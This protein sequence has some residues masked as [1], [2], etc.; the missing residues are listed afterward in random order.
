MAAKPS[1]LPD[2]ATGG[3]NTAEPTAGEKI[4][5]W[6]LGGPAV[7]SYFNWL[8]KTTRDWLE[9]LK[10]GVMEGA[11][12]FAG[13]ITA[14]AGLTADAGQHITVSGAGEFKHGDRTIFIGPGEFHHE[15]GTDMEYE[16]QGGYLYNA[17][18]VGY[19]AASV[20]LP[21]ACRIKTAQFFYN[22]NGGGS[23]TPSVTR[24]TPG[25]GG[26]GTSIVA[27]S[28]DS[29]GTAIESQTLT[30]SHTISSSEYPLLRYHVSG[31]AN[32]IHGVLLTYDRP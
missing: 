25:T 14:K 23:I 29:T 28:A 15:A 19:A 17:S 12:S 32:R 20:P 18:A 2:W 10:D 1:K 5:G 6:P 7:S 21:A 24:V 31:A 27:G 9:Y 4:T 22:P 26:A 13:L 11:W 30:V 8:A 3:T 16:T